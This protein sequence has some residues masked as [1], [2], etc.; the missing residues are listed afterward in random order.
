MQSPQ[1]G[2]DLKFEVAGM[3]P[4]RPVKEHRDLRFGGKAG[5]WIY[6]ALTVKLLYRRSARGKKLLESNRARAIR[7]VALKWA[8]TLPAS[9]RPP[10]CVG[11]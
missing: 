5:I 11:D 3:Q 1:L 8:L 9:F 4:E 7:I 2:A 10:P 6:A